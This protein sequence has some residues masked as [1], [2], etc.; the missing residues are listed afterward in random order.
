[1]WLASGTSL[2]LLSSDYGDNK[3]SSAGNRDCKG[4]INVFDLK[5]NDINDVSVQIE[6][7]MTESKN[8]AGA[9]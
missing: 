6:E 2:N 8:L 9:M 3:I 4:N 7:P 5:I 1:M